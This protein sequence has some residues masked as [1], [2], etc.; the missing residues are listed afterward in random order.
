MRL[1][2]KPMS[3]NVRGAR[4]TACRVIAKNGCRRDSSV[5]LIFTQGETAM[6]DSGKK[7]KAKGNSRKSLA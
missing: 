3:I 1:R 7:I 6:G 5:R 2:H 4:P